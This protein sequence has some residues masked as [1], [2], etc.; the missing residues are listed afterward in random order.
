MQ[1]R[2]TYCGESNGV[3]GVKGVADHPPPLAGEAATPVL[4]RVRG[5]VME[6]IPLAV[7]LY[8]ACGQAMSHQ[9]LQHVPFL[10]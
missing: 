6:V 8:P 10:S 1:G 9:H 5:G 2:R 3:W 7:T 4:L